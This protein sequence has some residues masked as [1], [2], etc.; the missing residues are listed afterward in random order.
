MH[1][2]CKCTQS[3]AL[4]REWIP[5]KQNSAAC[6]LNMAPMMLCMSHMQGLQSKKVCSNDSQRLA[7]QSKSRPVGRCIAARAWLH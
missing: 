3:A 7:A 4:L 1:W 6:L 5:W 2:H